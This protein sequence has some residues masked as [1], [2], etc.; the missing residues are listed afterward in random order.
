MIR[1]GADEGSEEIDTDIWGFQSELY[2]AKRIDCWT[3]LE[4]ALYWAFL[5]LGQ[6]EDGEVC[7]QVGDG[8]FELRFG[9]SQVC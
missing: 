7:G 9:F 8:G 3:G 6:P 5:G 1:V 4:D 2:M